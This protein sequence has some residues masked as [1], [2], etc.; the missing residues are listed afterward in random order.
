MS[1]LFSTSEVVR[2]RIWVAMVANSMCHVVSVMEKG[3]RSR[4]HL[5][6]TITIEL[7]TIQAL[8]QVLMIMWGGR[9]RGARGA[10]VKLTRC[11]E[12]FPIGSYSQL[13]P[14]SCYRKEVERWE[15]YDVYV[16]TS[17]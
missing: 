16:W 7:R 9:A 3:K 10:V 4:I 11:I 14:P 13:E 2:E 17:K 15:V 1:G 8:D 6:K 12:D 5:L